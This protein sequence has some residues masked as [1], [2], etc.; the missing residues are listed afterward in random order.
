MAR[1]AIAR[2][3]LEIEQARLLV[4]RT[5]HLIDTAGAKVARREIAMIKAV[6]PAM[7][8]GVIDRAIQIHGAAGVSQDTFLARA[9]SIARTLRIADGPDEV[10][11]ESVARLELARAG[12]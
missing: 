6:A 5:A 11:L 3:R 12:K 4:L 7:A 1:E 8:L 10:H 9:W 2:S